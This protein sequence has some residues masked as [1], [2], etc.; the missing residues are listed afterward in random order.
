LHRRGWTVLAHGR[1]EAKLADIRAATGGGVT[2]L[3]ADLDSLAS[4]RSHTP[5]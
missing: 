1:S 4:V 5:A 2:G 3:L